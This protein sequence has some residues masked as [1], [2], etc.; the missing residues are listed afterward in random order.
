MAEAI[1]GETARLL[2]ALRDSR[3]ACVTI[4]KTELIGQQAE[5]DREGN[6]V[7]VKHL[8]ALKDWTR[9][10]DLDESR[11]SY[12]VLEAVSPA[13]AILEFAARNH[14]SHIV[15]GA[16]GSSAMRRHLGSVSTKV[17]AE[18]S[19]SVTVIR[20]KDGLD[21]EGGEHL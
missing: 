3:P 6:S 19:C 4:W 16:R 17:V 9:P 13:D 1:R 2:S 15:M 18:A 5:T 11:L 8:V 21:G 14:A 12:H 20:V 7:Y 10:L